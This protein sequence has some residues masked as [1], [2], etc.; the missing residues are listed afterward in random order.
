V[1]VGFIFEWGKIDF[2]GIQFWHDW[3]LSCRMDF[4]VENDSKLKL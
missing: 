4:V 1:Y 3:L 2:N